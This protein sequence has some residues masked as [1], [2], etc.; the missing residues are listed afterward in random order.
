MIFVAWIL[1]WNNPLPVF[2]IEIIL[3]MKILKIDSILQI[4]K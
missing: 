4:L 2:A 1:T 3:S